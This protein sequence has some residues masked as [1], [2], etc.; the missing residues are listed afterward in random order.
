[1]PGGTLLQRSASSRVLLLIAFPFS[2]F[3]ATACVYLADSM[4]LILARLGTR[5]LGTGISIVVSAANVVADVR[6]DAVRRPLALIIARVAGL[7]SLAL[8]RAP[9]AVS[10]LAA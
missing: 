3:L 8:L 10:L 6:G 7:S 9:T 5:P 2:R 1:V 4:L